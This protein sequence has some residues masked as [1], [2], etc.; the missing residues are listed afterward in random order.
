MLGSFDPPSAHEIEGRDEHVKA[1]GVGSALDHSLACARRRSEKGVHHRQWRRGSRVGTPSKGE[2]ITEGGVT[3]SGG[4]FGSQ[5][6]I[7]WAKTRE[8]TDFM[9]VRHIFYRQ[10]LVDSSQL[11]AALSPQFASQI[12]LLLAEIGLHFE[13]NGSLFIVSGYQTR[14]LRTLAMPVYTTPE[15]AAYF[16]Y[17]ALL[18]WGDLRPVDPGLTPDL[19]NAAQLWLRKLPEAGS[20]RLVWLVPIQTE[21]GWLYKVEID[22]NSGETIRVG[23][24]GVNGA[25]TPAAGSANFGP[26]TPQLPGLPQRDVAAVSTPSWVNPYQSG[27]NFD[28]RWPGQTGRRPEIEVYRAFVNPWQTQ[29][30]CVESGAER[31]WGTVP[32]YGPIGFPVY[33][34]TNPAYTYNEPTESD[35]NPRRAGDAL[36]FTYLTFETLKTKF[37]WIGYANDITKPGRLVLSSVAGGSGFFAFS[38]N[39]SYYPSVDSVT[40]YLNTQQGRGFEACLDGVGHEW[41]HGAVKYATDFGYLARDGWDQQ[42]P[43]APFHEGFADVTAHIIEWANPSYAPSQTADWTIGTTCWLSADQRPAQS[44]SSDTLLCY[45]RGQVQAGTNCPPGGCQCPEVRMQPP[46]AH[47]PPPHRVGHMLSVAFRLLRVGGSNP[48]CPT[49]GT[50]ICNVSVQGQGSLADAIFFQTLV[51]CTEGATWCDIRNM[52]VVLAGLFDSEVQQATR[53]AFSAIGYFPDTTCQ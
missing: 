44:F 29:N 1:G 24:P 52:A 22:A 45:W 17:A 9:G 28:A 16:A 48:A 49:P 5:G 13:S 40:M 11:Y 43:W 4:D 51:S 41:G 6:R 2:G 46:E 34:D 38:E 7:V 21:D 31:Y 36:H 35:L 27:F 25:C 3:S 37:G 8:L 32:V 39:R 15:A 14:D 10:F 12:G 33:Q 20:L 18:H 50:Q 42:S 26:A 19:V 23:T 30:N 47:I 53:N